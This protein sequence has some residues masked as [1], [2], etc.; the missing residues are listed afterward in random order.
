MTV[1]YIQYRT[2]NQISGSLNKACS[3]YASASY[4]IEVLLM[5]MEFD[6]VASKIPRVT[7]N[8]ASAREQVGETL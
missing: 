2:S 6:P 7:V 3:L 4:N 1:K 5:D 8:T